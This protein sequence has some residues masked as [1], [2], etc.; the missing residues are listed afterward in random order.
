MILLLLALQ[1]APTVGDTVWVTRTVPLPERWSARAPAWEPD[2]AVELLGRPVLELVRGGG[3]GVDSV[4]VRYPLVAWQP[5]S[6]TVEVP[7]PV[8]LSPDGSVD[9]VRMSRA[10][11]AVASVLPAVPPDSV[12]PIQPPTDIVPRS[13]TSLLPLLAMLGI[14]ALLLAPLHWWWG[15]GGGAP[16]PGQEGVHQTDELP[17]SQ[18]AH[19][20]EYRAVAAAAAA[21]LRRTI[22]ARVPE[23]TMSLGLAD[24]L[25]QVGRRH[26]SW[27]L[28]DVEA[29]LRQLDDT[30]YAP[31]TPA[32]ALAMYERAA[33]LGEQLEAHR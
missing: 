10:T 29:V 5:G 16:A 18:W 21:R 6:F 19:A 8:L 28:A 7:G 2:G 24:W 33:A 20:G 14:A 27:P 31:A 23:A 25:A 17:V 11:I 13:H 9:S 12:L 30:R 32:D 3:G 26:P 22:A 1:A 4:R 15:R